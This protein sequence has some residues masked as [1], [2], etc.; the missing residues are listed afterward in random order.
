[1]ET[2]ELKQSLAPLEQADSSIWAYSRGLQLRDGV[3]FSLRGIPYL[4]DLVNPD[5]RKGCC[6]KGAQA[7]L[8]TTKFIEAMHGCYFRKYKQNIIYA[9]PTVNAV[10]RLCAVAFDPMFQYNDFIRKV[11]SKNTKEVKT[12]NG[13]S[14]VFV[15]LQPKRVGGSNV[16]DS[17][18]V[19]SIS[20]DVIYRDEVDLMDQDMSFILKQRLKASEFGIEFDFGSPTFPGYGIDQKYEESD[21]RRWMIRC[22]KCSKDTCLVEGFPRSVKLVGNKWQRSCTHCGEEIF[23]KDGRWVA[24]YPDRREAGFWISGLLSPLA[25]LEEYMHQYHTVDGRRMSEFMRSTLGIATTEAE[26]QLSQED[27]FRCCTPH[28]IMQQYSTPETVMGVDVGGSILHVTIGI[29]TGRDTYETLHVGRY[30]NFGQL[31]EVARK[32]NVKFG[33]IDALPDT[34]AVRDF[35]KEAPYTVYMCYYSETQP[36]KPKWDK[37]QGTVKVNR[38]EWCDNVHETYAKQKIQLPRQTPE[39]EELALEMTKTAKTNIENPDTGIPKP[40]WIKLG[41]NDHYFHSSLYFLL[42]ATRAVIST[43]GVETKRYAKQKNEYSLT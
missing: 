24:K 18:N 40:K 16:K 43:A 14:I 8:T 15:G 29:R 37:D 17:D 39:I 35:A 31:H 9:M 13:R 1:M 12:I 22:N 25:D 21:Q 28:R 36:G 23:V 42:A 19:R 5:K 4:A 10:E 27:V 3:E 7:F 30:D 11:T 2:K 6:K 33:V 26:N 38:N 20:C 34:H 41:D 32:M